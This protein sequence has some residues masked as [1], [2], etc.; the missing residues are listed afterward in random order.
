MAVRIEFIIV[1]ITIIA[2]AAGWGITKIVST[3][4]ELIDVVTEFRIAMSALKEESKNFAEKNVVVDV[5]LN[6]H[7]AKIEAHGIILAEHEIKI[8]QIQEK[9]GA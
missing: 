9:K 8:R 3:I 1:G 7:S 2:A 6:S 4:Q 5:R